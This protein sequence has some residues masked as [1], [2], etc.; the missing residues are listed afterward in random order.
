MGGAISTEHTAYCCEYLMDYKSMFVYLIRTITALDLSTIIIITAGVF[1][2]IFMTFCLKNEDRAIY[3]MAT[4]TG[5]SCIFTF[6]MLGMVDFNDMIGTAEGLFVNGLFDL[7]HLEP[8]LAIKDEL[9]D[10]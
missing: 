1:I 8:V 7:P 3:A 9:E 5:M 10:V 6:T 2:A 4:A